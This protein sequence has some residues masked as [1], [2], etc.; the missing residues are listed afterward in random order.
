MLVHLSVSQCILVHFRTTQ[1]I[2]VH[3][4]LSPLTS[5]I[6][7]DGMDIIGHRSYK[8]TFGANKGQIHL[9]IQQTN[10]VTKSL[11]SLQNQ[12]LRCIPCLRLLFYVCT[13]QKSKLGRSYER[14]AQKTYTF[15]FLGV[16]CIHPCLKQYENPKKMQM[17]HSTVQCSVQDRVRVSPCHKHL[18]K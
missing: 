8:S 15:L 2:L 13:T 12:S 1:F 18:K 11:L 6:C 9:Y 14:K 7:G 17:T 10:S 16:T 5:A 4:R 3:E